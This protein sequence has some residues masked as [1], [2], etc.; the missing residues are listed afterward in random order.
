VS[1][2]DQ[3]FTGDYRLRFDLWLNFPGPFPAGGAGSTQLGTAGITR[4][5][6]PQFPNGASTADAV[7]FAVTGDGGTDPDIRVYTNALTTGLVNVNT[8]VYAAG[9]GTANNLNAYYSVFGNQAAPPDQLFNYSSQSGVIAPGAFGMVWHD[10][11]ITKQGNTLT[12]TIDGLRMATINAYRFGITLSTNIFV[13]HSDINTGQTTV[14]LDAVHFG[15]VDNVVVESLAAPIAPVITNIA[16]VNLTNVQVTF[17]AAT[18]DFPA[19]FLLLS[20][21]GVSG[22]YTNVNATVTQ[23]SPGAFRAVTPYTTNSAR[24]YRILR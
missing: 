20:S 2:K 5:S 6:I 15:L 1:P 10:V 22:G 9:T 4:G 3:N 24:F 19:L 18:D 16:I 12:W 21:P 17:T 13:G 23:L 14:A 7:Y 11:V 8:G